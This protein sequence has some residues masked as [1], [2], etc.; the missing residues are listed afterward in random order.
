MP[1]LPWTTPDD[2][3]T[4]PDDGV[5]VLASRLELRSLRDVP[6]FLRAA[7]AVRQQV[8]HAPGALGVSLIAQ[9]LAKTFWTLSSWQSQA[10][11]D[12]FTGAEPHRSTMARF[13]PRMREGTF[14]TW[15]V[16]PEDV[17]P[18]WPDAQARIAGQRGSGAG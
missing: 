2:A 6:G 11:L 13:R 14:V 16:P 18:T 17:T 7:M 12:T 10:A 4:T 15:P 9:P 3:H 5:V 1:T 8:L